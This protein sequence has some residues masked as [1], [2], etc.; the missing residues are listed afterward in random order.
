M[1]PSTFEIRE[2]IKGLTEY[3]ASDKRLVENDLC[4]ISIVACMKEDQGATD[5][6]MCLW[7]VQSQLHNFTGMY[8][9]ICVCACVCVCVRARVCVCVCVCECVH[10][11]THVCV[12]L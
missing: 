12:C 9:H 8:D 2:K 3:T 1:C 7:R 11:C 6:V 10:V 5:S 4:T